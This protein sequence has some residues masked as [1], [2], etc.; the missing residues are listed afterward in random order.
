[1][2]L[3]N[4]LLSIKD[5]PANS[6]LLKW[7]SFFFYLSTHL[8]NKSPK[9]V[10]IWMHFRLNHCCHESHFYDPQAFFSHSSFVCFLFFFSFSLLVSNSILETINWLIPWC[11]NV[12][13][14][15]SVVCQGCSLDQRAATQSIYNIMCS[16]L[17]LLCFWRF[18]G[19]IQRSPGFD[20]SI[21]LC[22]R[23]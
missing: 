20:I 16:H 21:S 14:N 10:P 17:K 18:M 19:L 12:L 3:D 2:S 7:L 5:A 1:M 9:K 8:H 15:I 6:F 4:K 13:C 23:L 11:S 22:L